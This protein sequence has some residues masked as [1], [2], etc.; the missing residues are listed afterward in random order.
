MVNKSIGK[1]RLAMI[2]MGDDRKIANQI[3]ELSGAREP[4]QYTD[5]FRA[6]EGCSH[7]LGIQFVVAQHSSLAGDQRHQ[8]AVALAPVVPGIN[9][10]YQYLRF[11]A[12]EFD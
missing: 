11:C 10:V 9:I 5:L 2:N 7:S 6:C 8:I 1:G 3:H 12:C 4:A